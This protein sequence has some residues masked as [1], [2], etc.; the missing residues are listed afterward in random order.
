MADIIDEASNKTNEDVESVRVPTP[1]PS[2]KP[3]STPSQL[4]ASAI[5]NRKRRIE[6][7]TNNFDDKKKVKASVGIDDS[8]RFG[9]A[10]YAYILKEIIPKTK[11]ADAPKTFA[12]YLSEN[13]DSKLGD[14]ITIP[15]KRSPHEKAFTDGAKQPLREAIKSKEGYTLI[16]STFSLCEMGH[17]VEPGVRVKLNGLT[18]GIGTCEKQ[19]ITNQKDEE[20]DQYEVV[21][22]YG[23]PFINFT[24]AVMYYDSTPTYDE[25]SKAL[26][27]THIGPI[28]SFIGGGEP[29]PYPADLQYET[30][31]RE[32]KNKPSVITENAIIPFNI[33]TEVLLS[34]MSPTVLTVVR[35]RNSYFYHG[36]KLGPDFFKDS[37]PVVFSTVPAISS[38]DTDDLFYK[39]SDK[40][41]RQCIRTCF[42]TLDPYL[43]SG[44]GII[45]CQMFD[46]DAKQFGIASNELWKDV[47]PQFVRG[48]EAL[49][50]VTAVKKKSVYAKPAEN[51][52]EPDFKLNGY[53]GIL[54]VNM[55]STMS[56]CGIRVSQRF[57]IEALASTQ[58]SE[59]SI[60]DNELHSPFSS[61]NP[62]QDKA[63]KGLADYI[64]LNNYSGNVVTRFPVDKF[65][66]Y[67]VPPSG[68]YDAKLK[69]HE[70]LQGQNFPE[71]Q[72]VKHIPANEEMVLKQWL[73]VNIY[74][75]AVAFVAVKI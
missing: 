9:V 26:S 16:A 74:K 66:F 4:S 31:T 51:S 61:T 14:D 71:K 3:I 58:L 47:A 57:A 5:E 32:R 63:T 22:E 25:L 2:I 62:L 15:H 56:M 39:G 8:P 18:W 20:T 38:D 69:E 49:L 53:A 6:N 65:N 73:S 45:R 68:V 43:P 41:T 28:E 72:D 54:K 70:I 33:P 40:V 17:K 52:K 7:R 10:C 64:V 36:D 50:L 75:N 48:L 34:R 23:E 12:I 11:S 27:K 37:P 1:M 30:I 21:R 46:G 24:V 67:A 59:Q 55:A 29:L 42:S 35:V 44:D 60:N 13:L 19:W